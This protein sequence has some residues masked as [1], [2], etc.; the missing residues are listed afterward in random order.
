MEG[1]GRS[2]DY[3]HTVTKCYNEAID[4][5][6]EGTYTKE[7]IENWKTQLATVFNRGFWDGYYLGQRLG[8]WSGNYG[9]MAT[10]RKI[11][12][13]KVTNYFAN[14]NVAEI[15]LETGPLKVGDEILITGTTSGV[16]QTIVNE[17][18]L[19]LNPV[20]EAPKGTFCSVAMPEKIRRSDKVY[21][22]VD[23]SEIKHR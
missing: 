5:Y 21:K 6:L 19:E 2:V 1:R 10:K 11:Y 17:V 3:V 18:R 22:M 23:S 15:K 13:G 16:V 8:E 12:L 9:S 14:I 4:A 20:E 7:K